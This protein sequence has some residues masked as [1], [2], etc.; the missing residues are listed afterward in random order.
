MPQIINAPDCDLAATLFCGQAFRWS[1][2]ADG[3]FTGIVDGATWRLRPAGAALEFRGPR[4]D[5][6]R[7]YLALDRSLADIVATFPD[8]PPLR[9]AVARHWG[10]RVLRQDPWET[11]ASYIASSTKQIVQIRQIVG[12]LARRFGEPIDDHHHGHHRP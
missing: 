8:D 10:L 6:L 1:R 2:G 11:L 3:W 12:A 9:R 7:R 5:R 4:A